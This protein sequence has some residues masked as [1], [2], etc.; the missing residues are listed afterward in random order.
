VRPTKEIGTI[1]D[2]GTFNHEGDREETGVA[3]L[4]AMARLLHGRGFEARSM[5]V[6][7]EIE[8]LIILLGTTNP[9]RDDLLSQGVKPMDSLSWKKGARGYDLLMKLQKFR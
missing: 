6:K 1:T 7:Q 9:S 4:K 3:S 5:I 8:E 2:E